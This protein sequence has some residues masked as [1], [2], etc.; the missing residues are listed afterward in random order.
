MI[1]DGM[2]ECKQLSVTRQCI[3]GDDGSGIFAVEPFL[4]TFLGRLQGLRQLLQCDDTSWTGQ[5]K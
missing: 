5:S 2:D 3:V 1:E 4:N